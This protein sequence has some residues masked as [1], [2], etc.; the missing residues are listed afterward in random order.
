MNI[1]FT[2][3]FQGKL[4]GDG[5][6]FLKGTVADVEDEIA[7][8]LIAL[9]HAVAVDAPKPESIA[10]ESEPEPVVEETPVEDAPPAD[11]EPE[12]IA[13]KGRRRGQSA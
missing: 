9:G 3:D 8:Q 13:E 7:A 4:T 1:Q 2:H 11:P 5:L 6:F 12:P 10:V